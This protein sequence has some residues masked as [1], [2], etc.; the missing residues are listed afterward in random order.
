MLK[1]MVEILKGFDILLE[2]GKGTSGVGVKYLTRMGVPGSYTY[3]Y[4][5][6]RMARMTRKAK[7]FYTR[8][9]KRSTKFLNQF[10]VRYD[11]SAVNVKP[12]TWATA[13]VN[14]KTKQGGMFDFHVN[15]RSHQIYSYRSRRGTVGAAGVMARAHKSGILR[16][17]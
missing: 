13:I 10:R 2:Y 6:R 11:A 7:F 12:K 4:S 5:P 17:R 1:E 3:V 14:V 16:Y 15:L 8:F 9:L